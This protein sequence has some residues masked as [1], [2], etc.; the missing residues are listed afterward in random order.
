LNP[1]QLLDESDELWQEFC[2]KDF[3]N[4][5]INDTKYRTWRK[6]YRHL[7]KEREEKLKKITEG[8]SSKARKQVPGKHSLFILKTKILIFGSFRA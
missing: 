5:H 3:K 1:Q 8:I 2:E 4:R 6:F 7:V